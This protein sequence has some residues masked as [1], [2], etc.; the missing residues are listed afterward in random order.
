MSRTRR[1]K[2]TT[3]DDDYYES[4]G[5]TYDPDE[6]G[7]GSSRQWKNA[8]YARMGWEE[9]VSILEDELPWK[10]LGVPKNATKSQIKSA[11][12]VLVKKWHP[13]KWMNASEEEQERAASMTK[14]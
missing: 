4:K 8:F 14:R 3:W 5:Q 2:P 7:Y 9:A 1:R 12:R 6:E 13:D 11:Y 10:V